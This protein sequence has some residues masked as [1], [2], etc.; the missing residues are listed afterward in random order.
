MKHCTSIVAAL[1]SLPV[2]PA[3]AAQP[4]EEAGASAGGRRELEVTEED[5]RHWSYRPLSPV[6]PP[7]PAEAAWCRTPVDRF[8]LSELETKGIR[9]NPPAGRRVLI[10]RLY[11]DLTGLPPPPE[12]VDAF[13]ADPS[14]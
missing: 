14:P 5:R 9:P 11:F 4:P 10:R 13:V 3:A 8:I 2:L 7:A 6:E 1:L 12:E